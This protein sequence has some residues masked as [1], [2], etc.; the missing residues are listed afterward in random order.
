MRVLLLEAGG[1]DEALHYPVPAFH[2]LATEDAALRWDFF[3]RHYADDVRG[4]RDPKF[5]PSTAASVS[6]GRRRSAAARPT[7]R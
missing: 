5:T 2:G 6:A 1:D 7:T 4:R 3:V